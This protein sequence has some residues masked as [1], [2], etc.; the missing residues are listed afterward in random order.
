M[1]VYISRELLPE[2][3]VSDGGDSKISPSQNKI[4]NKRVYVGMSQ[5][6]L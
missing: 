6:S 1:T 4:K 5:V 2:Q 3:A